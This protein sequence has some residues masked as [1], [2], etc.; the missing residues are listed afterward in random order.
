MFIYINIMNQRPTSFLLRDKITFSERE[1]RRLKLIHRLQK[2][3]KHHHDILP[4]EFYGED[5]QTEIIPGIVPVPTTI[6]PPAIVPPTIIPT[7]TL[8]PG[9]TIGPILIPKDKSSPLEPWGV[10]SGR[11]PSL[12]DLGDP[13]PRNKTIGGPVEF[14]NIGD[15][16]EDA[17]STLSL[18]GL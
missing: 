18:L 12:K 16:M 17:A 14:V 13:I 11:V 4:P 15:L 2:R 9:R 8:G 1:S 5:T 6:V 10:T 3:Q 7:P